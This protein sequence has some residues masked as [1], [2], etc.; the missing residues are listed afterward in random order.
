MPTL[1]WLTRDE[2]IHSAGKAAYRL[3]REVPE[4]G[5]KSGSGR[6]RPHNDIDVGLETHAPTHN[7]I[8]QGDNLEALKALLPFYAGQVKCIYID[9][10]YNT[11]SA[12]THYDDNL[13]HTKWISMM[14]PRLELLRDLLAE[15]GSIWI[16]IDDN[17]GHY[18]KVICDEVFGRKNFLCDIAW[19]KRFSPPPDTKDFGYVHDHILVYRKGSAFCRNLLPLTENQSERYKNPDNDSRG[20]WQSADYT[21]RYTA[22]ERPN[23][24]YPIIH[25]KTGKE[26]WPKKT[27]V[28]AMSKEI[29]EHNV[30][31]NLIWWGAKGTQSVPRLKNFFS[32]IQQ[33][34]MPM[35][36]WKHTLAGHTQ[37]AAKEMLA[38]F[39][40]DKF[41]TPKPERLIH[42]ILQIA[43]NS[44]DLILDSF[45]GSGTTAAVA[46]KMGRRYIGIEMGDHARTHCAVRLQKVIEGEQGGISKAVGW[47]GGGG[48][49]FYT[50][51][52]TI[53]DEDGH[54]RKSITFEQL[55][56]HIW[57]YETKTPYQSER[58][59]P[60]PHNVGLETHVPINDV[61][62]NVQS[63]IKTPF[64][65]IHDGVGYALLYNGV[66]HDKRVN[67]GNVLTKKTL[68]IIKTDMGKLTCDKLVVYG[69]ASRL[70]D[71]HLKELGIEFKQ[72]PYN[73]R[74][75]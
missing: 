4:L 21:C 20:L 48:F 57:F 34:M 46:H 69:E 42:T 36:L 68:T 53:F 66:L 73:V 26:I 19:E 64:L 45:L 25:P 65:G 29:H 70:G 33:G 49:R 38:L 32:G 71:T 41:T 61:D 72:P 50:L 54:V 51:G 27:R 22:N 18:A 16:N 62:R 52:D 10:P 74:T 17:E 13:E 3:L 58:G 28:W 24:F 12:F 5:V 59:R 6:P 2:D 67:G 63:P 35:S 44:G 43:T 75:K 56:A 47:K 30:R 15:D 37:E 31:E 14:Y 60:R 23:L 55:A 8:I 11:G 9:P 40:V 39:G 1:H 7:M